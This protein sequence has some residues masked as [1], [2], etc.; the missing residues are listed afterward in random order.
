M[1]AKR[2]EIITKDA[3]ALGIKD[4]LA[5]TK[6]MLVLKELTMPPPR[7]QGRKI[8][9]SPDEQV[10]TLVQLLRSEAKVI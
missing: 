9:G 6:N 8:E 4:T 5:N 7:P 10:R 2:K 1:A 3:E